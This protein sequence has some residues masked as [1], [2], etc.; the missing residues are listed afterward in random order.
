M[1]DNENCFK[2]KDRIHEAQ[3]CG[4]EAGGKGGF[5]DEWDYD[6][7]LFKKQ[8]FRKRVKSNSL[9]AV[10]EEKLK[11][12]YKKKITEAKLE[13]VKERGELVRKK[14]EEEEGSQLEKKIEKAQRIS[15]MAIQKELQLEE[16]IEKEEKQ[17]EDE[18]TKELL[19][20]A[21]IEKKKDEYLLKAIKEKELED[22][23]NLSKVNIE[24]EIQN[25]REKAKVEILAKRRA[26]KRKILLMR[27]KNQRKKELIR[28]E[29]TTIRM[30]L[31]DKFSRV[32]KIGDQS[33]C[34][35]PKQDTTDKVEKYCNENYSDDYMKLIDC[36]KFENFCY[37]CCEN[38]YGDLHIKE[39]DGCYNICDKADNE[40][41][42]EA[43]E[44]N[45]KVGKWLS[46]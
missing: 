38:E 6:F 16:M 3:F 39:R 15:L 24:E 7:N 14:E 23:R 28:D 25:I 20:Q 9:F 46:N 10:D 33:R 19:E 1:K 13:I 31:A 36:K 30:K 29:I 4:L 37:M 12:E 18:E 41:S 17:K 11:E 42:V 45:K 8:C 27:K 22:Q 34:F 21:D 2:I 26:I 5:V 40:Q 43:S 44:E 32:S 35:I